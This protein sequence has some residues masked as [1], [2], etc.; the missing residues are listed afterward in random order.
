MSYVN[1][2]LKCNKI[3]IGNYNKEKVTSNGYCFLNIKIK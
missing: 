2:Q 3:E 1:E